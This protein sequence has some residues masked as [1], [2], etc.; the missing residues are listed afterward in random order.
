[1]T[2]FWNNSLEVLGRGP[3]TSVAEGFAGHPGKPEDRPVGRVNGKLVEAPDK[4]GTAVVLGSVTVEVILILILVEVGRAATIAF[5]GRAA[6][7]PARKSTAVAKYFI[8]N[9]VITESVRI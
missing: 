2:V 6:A 1:M 9:K 5:A 3:F 8:F 4:L 7:K